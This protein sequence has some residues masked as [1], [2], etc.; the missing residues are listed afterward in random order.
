MVCSNS[1]FCNCS[2]DDYL[3]YVGIRI[4]MSSAA[5]D[6][7][8]YKQRLMDWIIA[9]CL[10]FF[11]HYL[12]TLAV[13]ITE[14][15]LDSINTANAPYSIRIGTS[16]GKLSKYRYNVVIPPKMEK[17]IVNLK[18]SRAKYLIQMNNL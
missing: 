9:M 12:M 16:E 7:A 8:K 18:K 15:L 3:V 6:R 11:M 14:S 4:V 2:N 5:E 10:L 1:K 17:K 13:T